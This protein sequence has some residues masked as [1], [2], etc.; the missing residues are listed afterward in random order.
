MR[1]SSFFSTFRYASISPSSLFPS[2][3]V[4]YCLHLH[5]RLVQINQSIKLKAVRF[6]TLSSSLQFAP[7]TLK[8]YVNQPSVDFDSSLEP[9]QELVL[10]EEQ[11]KG[12]KAVELRYVRFQRLNHLSV[13]SYPLLR[14]CFRFARRRLTPWSSPQ[15]FVVD[16]QGNEE[17]SRIDKL[18]LI[19]LTGE[20][21]KM[22]EFNKEEDE[23]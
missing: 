6:T 21:M 9:A 5:L 11:A 12:L 18:E 14:P 10:D 1:T 22:S 16:N 13:R 4:L 20:G 19:G 8:L 15:I 23:H 17:I 3:I 2:L 7:R